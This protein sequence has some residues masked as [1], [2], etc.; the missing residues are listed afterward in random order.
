MEELHFQ[1]R[2]YSQVSS[3]GIS[4]RAP[5]VKRVLSLF[6]PN[7]S[8]PDHQF[9]GSWHEDA[10]VFLC[11]G[12]WF[13]DSWSAQFI[14]LRQQ[15]CYF[16][17]SEVKAK[18]SWSLPS[19]VESDFPFDSGLDWLRAIHRSIGTRAS[20]SF[21]WANGESSRSGL[22]SNSSI[23]SA[24]VRVREA[25]KPC[26]L[27]CL[28]LSGLIRGRSGSPGS[29]LKKFPIS[30][31]RAGWVG[32]SYSL[33]WAYK[34]AWGLEVGEGVRLGEYPDFSFSA[35]FDFGAGVSVTRLL[36]SIPSTVCFS[37]LSVAPTEGTVEDILNHCL[38]SLPYSFRDLSLC[39]KDIEYITLKAD[40][41]GP[42]GASSVL[43]ATVADVVPLQQQFER[44]T[45]SG[46]S[47]STLIFNSPKH[48]VA[49]YALPRLWVPRI[50]VVP[51]DPATGEPGTESFPPSDSLV[52]RMLVLRM[53][54]YGRSATPGYRRRPW[55]DLVVPTGWRRWGIP[56]RL[57][58]PIRLSGGPPLIDRGNLKAGS[59]RR[60]TSFSTNLRRTYLSASVKLRK[61][62]V[63]KAACKQTV[64]AKRK[65][66]MFA[67]TTTREPPPYPISKGARH[68]PLAEAK[69]L[70]SA[71][72][73]VVSV[74]LS[75]Q[76]STNSGRE[77]YRTYKTLPVLTRTAL[78]LAQMFAF[79]SQVMVTRRRLEPRNMLTKTFELRV[80]SVEGTTLPPRKKNSPA[81]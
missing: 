63:P 14:D 19:S 42:C 23:A 27:Q 45:Y 25:L 7:P 61:K 50:L 30:S 60:V 49:Y 18:A 68:F 2:F 26:L 33:I 21:L 69:R 72:R 78:S 47:G 64:H 4:S 15:D 75:V 11:I 59:E 71:L 41:E 77:G 46:I 5:G 3:H 56:D 65:G 38:Q 73:N 81:L 12:A 76:Q 17:L 62:D 13:Q 40:F 48:F 52:L 6:S 39:D 16:L 74:G 29:L 51:E 10:R 80:R 24:S 28:C 79:L 36:L 34:R 22:K 20:K 31:I 8:N 57:K 70:K 1:S 53:R 43:V 37:S 9:M 66:E 67:I 55:G 44:L 32:Y 35:V 58:L 54:F